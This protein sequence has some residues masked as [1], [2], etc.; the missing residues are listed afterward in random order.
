MG[1][2]VDELPTKADDS[3]GLEAKEIAHQGQH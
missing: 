1:F 2:R 3:S